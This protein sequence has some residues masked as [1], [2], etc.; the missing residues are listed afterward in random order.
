M[1]DI[2]RHPEETS[3]IGRGSLSY[4]AT[5]AHPDG[6]YSLHYTYGWSHVARPY[7]TYALGLSSSHYN[8]SSPPGHPYQHQ[9]GIPSPT[10][11]ALPAQHGT[12]PSSSHHSTPSPPVDVYPHDH[13]IRPF[14]SH[15]TTQSPSAHPAHS[16][17]VGDE[18]TS[19]SRRPPAPHYHSSVRLHP[20]SAVAGNMSLVFKSGYLKEGWKW[21]YVPESQRD[22]Y[23]LRWKVICA[24]VALD[25]GVAYREGA[26]K[27]S[28]FLLGKKIVLIFVDRCPLDLY[29]LLI[30]RTKRL[31]VGIRK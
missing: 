19:T 16:L 28:L 2:N 15:H 4:H 20:S 1:E 23:W 24:P 11:H 18:H 27:A 7:P 31:V 5:H 29:S 22:I 8:S 14:S 25:I 21:E 9:H 3:T 10:V 12:I 26:D 13:G 17:G 6:R 30:R